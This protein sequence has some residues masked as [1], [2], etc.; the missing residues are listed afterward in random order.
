MWR[1]IGSMSCE[2]VGFCRVIVEG[3]CRLGVV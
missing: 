3:V 2:F 1:V